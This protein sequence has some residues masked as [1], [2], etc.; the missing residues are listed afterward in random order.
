MELESL[1]KLIENTCGVK[2]KSNDDKL[3]SD[4]GISS[5]QVMMLLCSIEEQL[6]TDIPQ[7]QIDNSTS[8][9][10]LFSLIEKCG[11]NKNGFTT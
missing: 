10:K 1:Y 7:C 4:L 6:G 3:V 9:G 5:F 8:V 2:I 11:R